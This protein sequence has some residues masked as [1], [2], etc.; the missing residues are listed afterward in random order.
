MALPHPLTATA[1]V[2]APLGVVG[3]IVA[4]DLGAPGGIVPAAIFAEA[5]LL[6][7]GPG[8]R[9]YGA[10]EVDVEPVATV[11][12]SRHCGRVKPRAT[13]EPVTDDAEAVSAAFDR[14]VLGTAAEL[15]GLSRTMLELTVV[16]AQ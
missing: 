8:L 4:T 2:A 5:Y 9:V 11:D 13:G 14:G 6:R 3:S 10:H 16:Y 15:L 1:L 7:S 12:A